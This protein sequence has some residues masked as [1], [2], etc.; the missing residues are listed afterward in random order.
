MFTIVSTASWRRNLRIHI[1]KYLEI[2]QREQIGIRKRIPNRC[3]DII[4]ANSVYKVAIS[5]TNEESEIC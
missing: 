1:D 4:P 3:V 5:H 2:L